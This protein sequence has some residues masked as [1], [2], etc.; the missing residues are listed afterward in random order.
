MIPKEKSA[1]KIRH[2]KSNLKEKNM[3]NGVMKH[4]IN[5]AVLP[6]AHAKLHAGMSGWDNPDNLLELRKQLAATVKA[7]M[8]DREDLEE[9]IALLAAFVWFNRLA[10][11]R[12]RLIE[13]E[14]G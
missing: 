8:Y 14:W 4:F 5:D 1:P 13:A 10:E 12:R 2:T 7:G 11:E 9:D 6:K 3:L